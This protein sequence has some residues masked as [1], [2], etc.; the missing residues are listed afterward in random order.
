MAASDRYIR[1]SRVKVLSYHRQLA[2]PLDTYYA[3]SSPSSASPS[4]LRR[5]LRLC[6]T[7]GSAI[8]AYSTDADN[9]LDHRQLDYTPSTTVGMGKGRRNDSTRLGTTPLATGTKRKTSASPE[10][11]GSSKRQVIISTLLVSLSTCVLLYPF[12]FY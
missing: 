10:D 12:K 1:L 2:P 11:A 8:D 3:S 4:P 9:S 5:S 7:P 6:S